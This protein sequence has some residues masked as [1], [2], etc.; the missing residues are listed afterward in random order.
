ML[1]AS[2][3]AAITASFGNL[4][5]ANDNSAMSLPRPARCLAH[6]TESEPTRH[7]AGRGLAATRDSTAS[8]ELASA[9]TSIIS[10]P[11]TSDADST[12]AY[13]GRRRATPPIWQTARLWPPVMGRQSWPQWLG[14]KPRSELVGL[15][16]AF[17]VRFIQRTVFR[18]AVW[19]AAP[20]QALTAREVSPGHRLMCWGLGHTLTP[21][22]GA[23]GQHVVGVRQWTAHPACGEHDSSSMP[24][25][26]K[27]PVCDERLSAQVAMR[28]L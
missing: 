15:G 13:R 3:R 9:M 1:H 2:N 22:G 17:V 24:S 28:A 26:V 18:R 6:D 5:I 7:A 14:D 20:H 12:I 4:R 23:C 27:P 19:R 11:A 25:S 10:T 16:V 8:T 21:D